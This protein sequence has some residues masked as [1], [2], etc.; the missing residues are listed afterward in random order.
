MCT[1]ASTVEVGVSL[2][3]LAAVASIAGAVADGVEAV[4]VGAP[5]RV[6]R[7]VALG[8]A[9]VADVPDGPVEHDGHGEVV[10]PVQEAAVAV[11]EPRRLHQEHVVAPG[12]DDVGGEGR[13][14]LRLLQAQRVGLEVV[15]AG[16]YVALAAPDAG[17]GPL[18]RDGV[19]RRPA[20]GRAAADEVLPAVD[21][22][23]EAGAASRHQAVLGRGEEVGAGAEGHV[24]QAPVDEPTRGVVALA[25]GVE[26]RPSLA[27]GEGQAGELDA[28]VV[29]YGESGWGA[30]VVA[31]EL[32]AAEDVVAVA[33]GA[34]A[35]WIRDGDVAAPVAASRPR[36]PHRRWLPLS[37]R[38]RYRRRQSQ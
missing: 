26:V 27:G 10:G 34:D 35:K 30:G 36:Q 16:R 20:H 18:P 38:R 32:E 4:A 13:V 5:A 33:P 8:G 17:A 28:A 25:R 3:P 31:V 37:R 23:P 24:R 19:L 11:A 15:D 7:G 2:E 29:G 21:E 6:V 22:V 9:A 1:C 14:E 12:D